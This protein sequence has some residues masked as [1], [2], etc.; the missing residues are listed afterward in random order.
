MDRYEVRSKQDCSLP[1]FRYAPLAQLDRVAHYECEGWGF[2]S[3]MA[4]QAKKAHLFDGSF[5]FAYV[6]KGTR[7]REGASVARASSGGS[8]SERSEGDRMGSRG[9]SLQALC[10]RRSSPSWRPFPSFFP[11]FS[12][13]K[14]MHFFAFM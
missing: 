2:E 11:L 1:T 10:R 6:V 13:M 7:T 14:H 8:R 4:H 3:L 12:A 5:S 9:E